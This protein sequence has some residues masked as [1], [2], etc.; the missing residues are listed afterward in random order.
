LTETPWSSIGYL[1]FKRTYARKLNEDSEATEEWHDTI[2]RVID[3]CKN[4]LKVGFTDDEEDRL[5]DYLYYLKGFVAG[6]FLWQ[7]GTKTVDRLGLPSLQNCAFVKVDEAVDPFV[8]TFHMLMLGCGVGFN[9]QRHN[10]DKIPP[11]KSWFKAP[12]VVDDAGADFIVPDS[13]EGWTKL[14]GKVLKAAFFSDSPS[15]GTFTFSTQVVRDFGKPIKG[16]GGTASG[17][18]P[19]VENIG[20]ISKV[21][22]KRRNRKLRPIDALD[23]MNLIGATVVAGNVRRCLPRATMVHTRECMKPIEEVLVGDE[24]LTPIGYK[25]VLNNFDQGEQSLIRIHTQDGWFDCTPNHRMGV[26]SGVDKYKW[27]EA[28]YLLPNDR[29]CTTRVEIDGTSQ[30]WPEN[31]PKL[32]SDMAWLIGAIHGNGYVYLKNGSG[33]LDI[34]F[35]EDAEAEIEKAIIQMSRFGKNVHVRKTTGQKSYRL[36]VYNTE[37]ANYLYENIKQPKTPIEIPSFIK[38]GRLENRLGYLAGVLDTDGSA[39]HTPVRLATSKYESFI[40]DLQLLA[41]SC[42]LETRIDKHLDGY[43]NLNIITDYTKYALEE[44]S[45]KELPYGNRDQYTS[46]YPQGWLYDY[47][48]WNSSSSGGKNR[49]VALRKF[50]EITGIFPKMIPVKVIGI[51]KIGVEQTYD[52]E[53]EDANCFFANGYLTHNSAEIAI[54]DCDDIECLLAKRFDLGNVPS[55]RAMS[56]NSVVCNDIDDLHEYF[57][58]TYRGHNEPLGLINLKLAQSCGRLGDFDYPDPLV[59]GFNPSMWAA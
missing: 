53:V 11:I 13:S 19:L 40:R 35:H 4:Q 3:A 57:W 46:T 38:N 12:T 44:Y 29:L 17:A 14:L 26:M 1:T 42:G 16:F 47:G 36:R 41:Y 45:C 32:D 22:E 7:L 59:E 54:F 55:H 10:V 21:L 6:R 30:S 18:G 27:V 33:Y 56:N 51:E 39:K 49:E 9:I 15:K 8:W 50:S 25:K 43:H 5:Y 24:V 58:D 2:V 48:H 28:Q 34:E 37:L 31:L 20:K 52:I 23:I